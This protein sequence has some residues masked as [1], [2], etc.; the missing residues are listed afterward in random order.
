[1]LLI[2]LSAVDRCMA[3]AREGGTKCRPPAGIGVILFPGSG[4]EM[5]PSKLYQALLLL[6]MDAKALTHQ[7]RL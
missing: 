3:D 1:M 5:V 2:S 4:E 6:R 7:M